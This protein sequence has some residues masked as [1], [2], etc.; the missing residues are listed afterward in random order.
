MLFF[1]FGFFLF[2]SL[3]FLFISMDSILFMFFFFCHNLIHLL[4]E[5]IDLGFELNVLLNHF[6]SI[7][8]RHNFTLL[9]SRVVSFVK[10]VFVFLFFRLF[11]LKEVWCL[12]VEVFPLGFFAV[13]IVFIVIVVE[14]QLSLFRHEFYFYLIKI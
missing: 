10:I 1:K 5:L 8:V 12:H 6:F 4:G 14:F 2:D 13:E 9:H 3:I 7:S 11:F